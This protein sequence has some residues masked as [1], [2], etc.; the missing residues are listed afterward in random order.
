MK[1]ETEKKERGKK[2]PYET[3]QI[4]SEKL[5]ESLALA[6]TRTSNIWACQ[7]GTVSS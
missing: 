4:Q 3:P 1:K 2:K 7:K 6:C 5:F